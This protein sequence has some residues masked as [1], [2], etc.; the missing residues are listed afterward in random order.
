[1][2]NSRFFLE[3]IAWAFSR[4]VIPAIHC[5]LFLLPWAKTQEIKKRISISVRAKMVLPFL[6]VEFKRTIKKLLHLN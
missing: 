2:E 6:K 3:R 4:F 5:N 1:M